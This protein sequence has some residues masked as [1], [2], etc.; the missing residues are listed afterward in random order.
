MTEKNAPDEALLGELAEYLAVVAGPNGKGG[1][2]TCVQMEDGSVAVLTA[3]HVVWECLR[4]TGRVGVGGFNMKLQSPN[5]IR[6]D[7]TQ[8]GD[9]ALVFFKDPQPKL[10]AIPFADWTKDRSDLQVGQTVYT[11]GFPGAWRKLDG[12]HL[13]TRTAVMVTSILALEPGRVVSGIVEGE[14]VPALAGLS[15]AGLFSDDGRFIGV[16]VERKGSEM[17]SLLPSEYSELYV[18]FSFPPGAP[19]PPYYHERHG[20]TMVLHKLD[21]T[22]VQ[23]RVGAVADCYWA[24]AD[25]DHPLGR[26]GRIFCLE[27]VVPGINKHYPMNMNSKFTWLR[28]TEEDRRKAMAEEFKFLLL[29]MRWEIAESDGKS[30]LVVK[31]LI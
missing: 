1:T 29:R 8:Q 15:G 6:M 16:V 24:A 27:F 14:G 23:A 19:P 17:Y 13:N 4:N 11:L 2:G 12:P 25:P 21:G 18:P 28:H 26:I 30:T 7:S 31:P 9:A 3:K 5:M 20:M 10:K 22:G